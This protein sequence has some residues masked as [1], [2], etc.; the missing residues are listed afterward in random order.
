M[1]DKKFDRILIRAAMALVGLGVAACV[2]LG[3]QLYRGN[4][5]G[6]APTNHQTTVP[7]LSKPRKIDA[8]TLVV[9]SDVARTLGLRTMEVPSGIRPQSLPAMT[10]VLALDHNLLSRV[11]ARFAGEIVGLGTLLGN[12]TSINDTNGRKDRSLRSGD[13]VT[14]GQLLAVLWSK[15]LGEKKS[16]LID[17]LSRLKLDKVNLERLRSA[18]AEAVPER[19]LR[20]AERTVE[21]DLISVARVERTLRSWRLSDDEIAE[22]RSEADRTKPAGSDQGKFEKWAR[23]EVRSPQN[24]I[25]LEKNLTIGDLVD[26]AADLF[27]IA[28]LRYLTVW[29]HCYEEDLAILQKLPRPVRWTVALP[30]RPDF[31]FAGE[32]EQIGAVIDPNQHT[33]L[34]TGRV[35]NG[36]GEL[37]VGQFVSVTIQTPPTANEIEVPTTT[38]V[39]DGKESMVFVQPNPGQD[40]YVRRKVEVAR[41]FHDVVYLRAG[42]G[43]APGERVVT[44]GVVLLYGALEDL[45]VSE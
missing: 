13:A 11:H 18:S 32:M 35:D 21:A 30:A 22:V 16:E 34:V 37:K 2:F 24:G 20:E 1:P 38:L 40:R 29:A 17:A 36:A 31:Y 9:P 6:A 28:D 27:K 7:E 41:R 43:L 12:E 33:A 42:A 3:I 10:G 8:D 44:G 19:A 23:V 39:E 25:L 14:K 4:H 26:T 5:V 15:D 45:P